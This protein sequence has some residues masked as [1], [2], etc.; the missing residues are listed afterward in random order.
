MGL[1]NKNTYEIHEN[2]SAAVEVVGGISLYNSGQ[3]KNLKDTPAF[4]SF[5]VC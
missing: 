2:A 3:L 4:S 1:S 5:L